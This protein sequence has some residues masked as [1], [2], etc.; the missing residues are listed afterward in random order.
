MASLSQQGAVS[1]CWSAE[2]DG[3]Q[4]TDGVTSWQKMANG[5]NKTFRVF[6]KDHVGGP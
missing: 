2:P 1:S 3:P 6:L 4:T 5:G